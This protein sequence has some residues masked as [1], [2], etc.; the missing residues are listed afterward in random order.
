MGSP[1]DCRTLPV[2]AACL[3]VLVAATMTMLGHFCLIL[4]GWV[5][6]DPYRSLILQTLS[7]ANY[8]CCMK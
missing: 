3:L 2:L 6:L 5:G 4:M 8:F 1:C 7:I